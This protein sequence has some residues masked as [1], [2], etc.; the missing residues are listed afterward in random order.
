MHLFVVERSEADKLKWRTAPRDPTSPADDTIWE[1][2]QAEPGK[3]YIYR[4]VAWNGLGGSDPS[5]PSAEVK[6]PPECAYK[7]LW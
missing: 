7:K 5:E 6:A 3:R 1:D 4:V 2:T